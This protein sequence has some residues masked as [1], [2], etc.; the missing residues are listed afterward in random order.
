MKPPIFVRQL[1]KRERERLEAGL[2]SKDA[3]VLRHCQILLASARGLSPPK[4]ARNL[5][6]GSQTARNAI[7]AFNERGLDSLTAGSS[8]PRRVYAAFDEK[9]AEALKEMLH[10]SPREFGRESSL[11]TLEMAAQAA[12]EEGLTERRVS[13]ETIRAT[14]SRLLGV[15]W[16]RAKRWIT[17]PIPCTKEKRR[18]DR[19]M[20]VAEANPETW[21]VGFEDECW[22]S[23][24]A[25]PTL[26]TWSEEG[27]PLRLLQR[28]VAKNDPEPKAISCYGL[29]LPEIGDTWLRFVD[30]RPVSS[31][32][33]R[34]LSWCAEKLEAAGKKVLLLIWD[35]ASWHISKEVRRWLGKH[36]R[37][38]K[39]S[40]EGVRIVVCLLPKQSP[41]LNAIE[42]KWVHAKRKVIEPERLLGAYELADRVCGVFGCPHYEHLYVTQEVAWSCTKACQRGV[43]ADVQDPGG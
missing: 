31:I 23:R 33:T 18:R 25:L 28:S 36:N 26:N 32:T 16:L 40:G 6:C 30:G 10:R 41:W 1:S 3:F 20:E 24:L 15:G 12:F 39:K 27:K 29:Y 37:R 4:I 21:A 43:P 35:K 5:G 38:V 19:L 17:S 42:P 7:H 14:L 13:G 2:R 34:F 8:R 11:W 9:S 22:W